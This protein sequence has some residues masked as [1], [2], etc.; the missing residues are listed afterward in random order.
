MMT[1]VYTG[2]LPK[3]NFFFKIQAHL[4]S[5][6]FLSTWCILSSRQPVGAVKAMWVYST[7]SQHNILFKIGQFKGKSNG[8]IATRIF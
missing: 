3:T 2:S 8:L 1:V 4:I 6:N 7:I 5:H